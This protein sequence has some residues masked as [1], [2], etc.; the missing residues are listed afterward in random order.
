VENGRTAALRV[1]EISGVLDIEANSLAGTVNAPW[2]NPDPG[3]VEV[4]CYAWEA[5]DWIAHQFATVIPDGADPYLCA[6]DAAEWNIQPGHTVAVVYHD[7]GGHQVVRLFSEPLP[8]P[9]Y[10]PEAI[11]VVT[12]YSA[13]DALARLQAGELSVWAQQTRDPD[14]AAAVA[15]SPDLEGYHAYGMYNELT[16]NPSGPIFAGTGKL[17]PFA[18]P[19]IRE[20]MNWLMDRDYIAEVIIG[21]MAVPRWHALNTASPDYANLADVGRSLELAYAYNPELA[22]QVI[23]QEMVL[24]GATRIGGKW[25]YAGQPVEIIL[26]IRIEDERMS[27]GDYVGDQLEAI[28][29]T[30]IRDYKSSAEASPIWI[31]GDPADGLFHIY[32]GGWITTQVP[33]D[34]AGNFAFFYTDMGLDVPLWQAYQN[35]PEFYQLAE[36]LNGNDFASLEERRAMMAQALDWALADSVR[37]WLVDYVSI[38][39]R[40]AELRYASELYGGIAASWLWPHTLRATDGLT[41]PLTIGSPGILYDAWNPL[42]GSNWIYDGMIIKATSDAALIPDPFTGLPI[43]QRI[44][45]ATVVAETGLTIFAVSDWLDLQFA[46]TIEIPADAWAGWDGDA[47]QF[48]TAAEVYGGPETARIKSV[49]YYPADLYTAVSW[50][51]GS[52]ISLGDFVMKMILGFERGLMDVKAVRIL[53]ENP[54]IIETYTDYHPLEAESVVITWWP[55]YDTGPGAWHTL[56]L[57]LLAEEAGTAAFDQWQANDQ[58]ILWLDYVAWP[59]LIPLEGQLATVAADYIPYAPTLGQYVTGD[60]AAARWINLTGWHGTV[61]HLW[62]GTGPLYLERV[63]KPLGQ[64]SLKPFAAYPDDPER[65]DAFREAPIPAAS[66]SGPTSVAKGAAATFDLALTWL[67]EPY[68]VSDIERVSYLLINSRGEIAF[69]G[70]ATAV[71]DGLWRLTLTGDMTN[72]LPVGLNRLEF[73]VMSR[74][75]AVSVRAEWEFAATGLRI[76]SVTPASGTNDAATAILIAGQHFQPGA[77]VSLLKTGVVQPLTANF[78]SSEIMQTTVPAGLPLGNYDLR[79]INPDGQVDRLLSAFTVLSPTPP[80]ITAVSPEQG[81]NNIPITLDVYGGNF[82][83]GLSAALSDGDA[84]YPLVGLYVINSAHLRADVSAGIPPGLYTL[85]ITNPNGLAA[86][87]P[88]AYEALEQID[89]LYPQANSFWLNPLT[90][91]QGDP[92]TPTMGIVVRRLGGEAELSAVPVAFYYQVGDGD[93]IP[94]GVVNTPPLAPDS[95]VTTLPL[96]WSDLPAAGTYILHAV[97]DPDNAI[98]ETNAGNNSISRVVIILPPMADT[99]PPVVQSFAINGGATQ[100]TSRQVS[101]N[102]AAQDNPGGSGVVSLLYIEYVYIYSRS[103]WEPV[104]SSGWLPYSQASQNFPWLLNPVPGIHYVRAWAADAA[105]NISPYWRSAAINLMPTHEA[106]GIA[107]SQIHTYRFYLQ[108]GQ[109]LSLVLTSEMG[110][111]DVYVFGPDNALV[112]YSFSDQPVE[113]AEFIA[114]SNGVYQIEVFGFAASDYRLEIGPYS[115]GLLTSFPAVDPQSKTPRTEP[116]IGSDNSPDDDEPV[117]TPSAPAYPSL[118]PAFTIGKAYS[119]SPI[120]GLPITYTLTITNVGDGLGTGLLITDA[121]PANVSYLSGGDFDPVAGV[122]S[123][124]LAEL[125]PGEAAQLQFVVLLGHSGMVVNDQ[126]RAAASNEGVVS[127]WGA[128]VSFAIVPPTI[129]ASFSQSA[130]EIVVGSTVTFTDTSTT[131]GPTIVVWLW[132]FGDGQT[133]AAQNPTHLYTAVGLYTVS[134]QV[135]DNLGYTAT[136]TQVAAVTVDSGTRYLYLPLIVNNFVNQ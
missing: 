8:P 12:E 66:V 102:A 35:T 58:G 76:F 135:T 121:L 2:L 1:G 105:G 78:V 38:T 52:P 112:T 43:P 68:P 41:L 44:A 128:P 39:P 4:E 20:A 120:A 86:Q 11:V 28:G 16:F 34:L 134:L 27:I 7:P 29:F 49:V 19:R 21:G 67:D 123:W 81:I 88:A 61:G 136:Y 131:N 64:L 9:V 33:R 3:L 62:V 75:A 92:V 79:V 127:A 82:A 25:Y 63:Y 87:A 45:S 32:T 116:L 114:V 83:A 133:S 118:L 130:A 37:V 55:Y 98:P 108:A 91:R 5:P 117:Q 113:G 69:S 54:L 119:G 84:V 104:A 50:H 94:I 60:E 10:D 53:S 24:L 96:A 51:D 100:T 46:P 106:A 17:N 110:D 93:P 31:N 65:W 125:L 30:V 89:D 72:L 42:H 101:F 6:W 77:A 124:Q 57:G 97:I 56:A 73:V 23:A 71:A 80:E 74:R 90:V 18:A 70:E 36:R 48:R 107:Q 99:T 47:Q 115:G 15:A 95:Q 111:A 59:G 26:L 103:A 85:T 22:N 129:E 40:R 126:Y 132:D 122:V 14:V 109:G 13:A